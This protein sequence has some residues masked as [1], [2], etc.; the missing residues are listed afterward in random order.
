MLGIVLNIH[1]NLNKS[2]HVPF[3]GQKYI[4]GTF[5][6]QYT[7]LVLQSQLRRVYPQTSILFTAK[8]QASKDSDKFSYYS[9]NGI[10]PSS[11]FSS[12]TNKRATEKLQRRRSVEKTVETS[13]REGSIANVEIGETCLFMRSAASLEEWAKAKAAVSGS[14][15]RKHSEK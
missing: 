6:N 3:K 12:Y 13:S 2:N 14:L 8:I 4:T 5:A 11:E 7:N 1:A 10:E 15:K 9:N